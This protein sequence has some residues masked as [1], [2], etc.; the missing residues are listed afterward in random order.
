MTA[1]APTRYEAA[2]QQLREM[3]LSR[4]YLP[5]ER[6]VEADLVRILGVSRSTVRSVLIRLQEE[7][8]VH[9]EPNRGA[10]VSTVTFEEAVQHFEVREV[11][12]G[13]AARVATNNLKKRDIADLRRLHVE[14]QEALGGDDVLRYVQLNK[15][16]HQRIMAGAGD[17]PAISI[18]RNL[19]LHVV[20][21]QFQTVL[22]PGRRETSLN[23]HLGI[24]EALER[25]DKDQVEQA[26]REHIRLVREAFIDSHRR[27]AG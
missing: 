22:L 18:L 3:L 25:R 9:I 21:E 11:L 15:A 24:L 10:R 23:E 26:A 5:K 13:L 4:K 7:R 1:P 16:F 19:P 12:E 8:L 27:A 14:M 2:Y 17:H 20:R 6:L